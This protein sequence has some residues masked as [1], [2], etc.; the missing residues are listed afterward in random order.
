MPVW[1][2]KKGTP[3]A[4]GHNNAPALRAGTLVDMKA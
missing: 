3:S 1:F 4:Y 2:L